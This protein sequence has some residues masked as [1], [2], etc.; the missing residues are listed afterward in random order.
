MQFSK[1]VCVTDQTQDDENSLRV[2]S[3]EGSLRDLYSNCSL[4]IQIVL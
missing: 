4:T 3:V 2:R 1:A